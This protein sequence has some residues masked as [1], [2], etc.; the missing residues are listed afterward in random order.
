MDRNTKLIL[1][2]IAIVVMVIAGLTIAAEGFGQVQ[3]GT[4]VIKQSVSGQLTA[5]M[6]PGIFAKNF[7]T[8]TEWPLAETFYFTADD[9]G[10]G[11]T[12]QATTGDQSIEVRFNDGG[13]CK[14]S[15]TCRLDMPRSESEAIDLVTKFGY[16]DH[17]QVEQK[18]ILPVIRR[19]LIM[20]ANLMSS[21]DSYSDRRADFFN[22]SWD[23]I[24]NGIY[25][26]VDTTVTD[27]DPI[28]GTPI[29]HMRKEIAKDDHGTILRENNPLEGTGVTLSIFEIKNFIYEDKVKAQISTQQDAIMAVQTARANA[30]KA[31]QDALTTEAN[32]KAAVMKAEYEELEKKKRAEVQAQQL[33]EVATIAAQQQVD[34]ANLTKQQALVAAN[35]GLEVAAVDLK[36]AQLTAQKVQELARGESEARKMILASD[37]ALAQKLEVYTKAQQV[38][39]D[40]FARRAVPGVIMGGGAGGAGSATDAQ[41]FMELMTLKAAKDLN[42]DMSIRGQ[43]ATDIK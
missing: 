38:W 19:A 30:Q 25:K 40:A 34:V 41:A 27:P 23:Q 10:A 39:A 8:V 4:Y 20:T 5:I 12:A 16:R 6:K 3:A 13:V 21:K 11:N 17:A 15:G 2:L 26:T 9:E 36:A 28:T 37:G 32:G 33:Q 31:T 14:I 7:A 35:Q 43:T 22:F 18:L 1:F 42:L 24:A 29:T